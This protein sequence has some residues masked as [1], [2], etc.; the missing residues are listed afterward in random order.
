M[1][2]IAKLLLTSL[3]CV[4]FAV[5]AFAAPPMQGYIYNADQVPVPSP[6]AYTFSRELIGADYGIGNFSEPQ[7]MAVGKDNYLYILDSGNNRLIIFDEELNLRANLDRFR[8]NG[9]TLTLN[10]PKGLYIYEYDG[11]KM[12]YIADTENQRIIRTDTKGNVDR[13]FNKPYID[14]LDPETPFYP[15]KLVVDR[16]ERMFIVCRNINRGLVKLKANGDF[17]SF[18]GAP[19]TTI[20]P[21][22]II[23][24]TIFT[25]EQ[26]RKLQSTVPTEYSNVTFDNQGFIYATIA[27]N[28]RQKFFATFDTK[29]T[30]KDGRA[31]VT[32]IRKLAA[33]GTDILIRAGMFPPVGDLSVYSRTSLESAVAGEARFHDVVVNEYG[34]YSMLDTNRCKVFTYDTEGNL[35]HIIGNSSQQKGTFTQPTAVEFLGDQILVLEGRYSTVTFFRPT[36]YGDAINKA[37][38]A[39]RTGEYE[40]SEQMWTKV[41][42][43]N[44]NMTIAYSGVGKSKM[45]A[46][47]YK[48][49]MADF[50]IA[51]NPDFYSK[52]LDAYMKETIGNKFTYIFLTIVGG[53]LLYQLYRL[54]RAFRRFLREGV[55]KV[56]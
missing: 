51:Q 34:I 36:D 22:M 21:L 31:K 11:K 27:Q 8:Y 50:K 56:V 12:I 4:I 14:L 46:G 26:V 16:A 7:D 45:R 52:A 9:E 23:L 18:F 40:L 13:V 53:Y 55:K 54:I 17:D 15:T 32:A 49:A 10:G 24:R 43:M 41:L 35:L 2:R 38:I 25:R 5:P 20:S 47:D 6:M 48:G 29:P 42:K 19:K 30:D 33:D 39:Y 3:L 1:K 28:D 44:S 37:I